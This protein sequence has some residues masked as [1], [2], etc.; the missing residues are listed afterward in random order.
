MEVSV[1]ATQLETPSCIDVILATGTDFDVSITYGDGDSD[2][3]NYQE[4]SQMSCFNHQYSNE[5]SYAVAVTV[6]NT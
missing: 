6:S 1:A 2:T 4:I 5:G 3:F